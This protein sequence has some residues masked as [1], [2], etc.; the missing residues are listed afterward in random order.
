MKTCPP[1][2][3]PPQ[4]VVNGHK[5][6]GEKKEEKRKRKKRK[7]KKNVVKSVGLFCR[8]FFLYN[9]CKSLTAYGL[10]IE[11]NIEMY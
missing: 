2:N 8:F 6:I 7:E 9:S 3:E 10:W 1:L 5:I 4:T 11:I